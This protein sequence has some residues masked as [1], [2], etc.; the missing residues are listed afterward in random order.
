MAGK[1]VTIYCDA[2]PG[3]KPISKGLQRLAAADRLIGHNTLKYDF[4]LINRLYPETLRLEQ[5]VDTLIMARLF[6][7]ETRNHALKDWGERLRVA[8]GDFEGPW[9][10]CTPEMLDYARQDVVVTRALYHHVKTVETWGCLETETKFAWLMFLQEQN[11]FRLD[12]KAAQALEEALR[13]E[14]AELFYEAQSA[15]PPRF[16]PA[17]PSI[18]QS[19]FH[20]KSD[21]K[22]L[23][24]IA[25]APLTKIKLQDFNPGSRRQVAERLQELGWKPSAYG[26]NGVPTVDDE[27]LAALPYPQAQKL[28]RYFGISKMLGQLS[29][30]KTGWLKVVGKDGRVH[31]RVNTIGC[32]PGRC[33][34]SSPNMAQV[35]KKDLRMR[36][37]WVPRPGWKLVGCDGASIQARALAHYLSPYDKGKAIEREV[38]GDKALGTDTHSVNRDAL[39]PCGFH[40]PAHLIAEEAG[41]LKSRLRDG[42][43]RA[44]YC[45]LF[46]GGDFKLG[47]TLKE[48]IREAGL[49]VPKAPETKLGKAARARLFEAIIGFDKLSNAIKAVARPR[50]RGGRGY[51]TALS[52]F[53]VR[54]RSEH[55][56]LVF[57]MQS[58]EVSIM[59]RAA[60]IFHFEKCVAH[61]WEHGRDFAYC[62][63]VHDEVQIECRPEI[64]EAVGK[65]FAASIKEAGERLGSRCPMEGDYIV[66]N[67][68]KE[69]H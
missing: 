26:K 41:H 56:A 36:A 61:G 21:N 34:H 46:G 63:N 69:T 59:K 12:L 65:A 15:F 60:V 28:V 33:A 58:F 38:N 13:G 55:S 29:D 50:E 32:A 54:C 2:L 5:Q 42:A 1:D 40:V 14:L 22:R 37:V 45:V 49:I 25:G 68:W 62:A 51:L 30:G 6:D 67:N 20:P 8:K 16:V 23:G 17:A 48:V 52:G 35:S 10:V 53:H 19:V 57:L 7:P 4:P 43:K 44:L 18:S 11:G 27:I 24:Y 31:G 47:A 9:G 64:A 3:Y 66:G 39:E